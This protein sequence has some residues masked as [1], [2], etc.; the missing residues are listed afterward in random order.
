MNIPG[1]KNRGSHESSAHKSIWHCLAMLA[2]PG[3]GASVAETAFRSF[4]EDLYRD[5]YADPA[6]YF[7]PVDAYE[8]Y[9]RS[10]GDPAG[11]PHAADAK[12]CGLRNAFQQAIQF[13][14]DFFYKIGTAA[15]GID[16][17]A[18]GL[19]VAKDAYASA[20]KS[21][22]YPH[23]RGRNAERVAAL[24]EP[25]FAFNENNGKFTIT[26]GRYPGM[27]AGLYALCSAPDGKYKRTN[28]LRLDYNKRGGGA[29]GIDDVLYTMAAEHSAGLKQILG[30]I[31]GM[32]LKYS[33]KPLGAITSGDGWKVE[34][35]KNGKNVFGFF[36]EPDF[37]ALYIYFNDAKNITETGKKLG[38]DPEFF[39]WFRGGFPERTC[40][41]KNNR[42]VM[43]GNEKRRICGLSNRAEIFCS[44]EV[45]YSRS[46]ALIKLFRGV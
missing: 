26:C 23:L 16:A 22:D 40:A 21:L 33:V 8:K 12:E 20:V 38:G 18:S 15:D 36:A 11:G 2:R 27:F 10:A 1:V 46:A 14:P 29:P 32:D 41:C 45:D 28:Y 30:V 9:I 19:I 43:F 24:T 25:R 31:N 17:A 13:Y 6:K 44:N 37:L 39:E 3:G 7:I 4:M 34:Y 5:M 35:K 42:A